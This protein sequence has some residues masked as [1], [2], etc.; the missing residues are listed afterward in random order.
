MLN[1][2][3]GLII[4]LLTVAVSHVWAGT[5]TNFTVGD[6]LIGFREAGQNNLVVDAGQISTFTNAAHNQVIPISQYTPNQLATVG[7]NGL[8][9]SAFSW[10]D[11][12]VT[13]A[14]AQWTLF[15]TTPRSSVNVKS[16]YWIANAQSA[17]SQ[18]L[19][20]G[21]M[22]QIPPGA[23][24][25]LFFN[26]ANTKTAIV[27]PANSIGS[28][29]YPNG[30]SY[31]D[32][33]YTQNQQGNFNGDLNGFPENTTPNN[34][35]TAGT[36]QRSDFYWVPP[37]DSGNAVKYLGYFE[38]NT[39]G[40]LSFVA[41]PTLPAVTSLTASNITAANALLSA[42]INPN[43]STTSLFF[44][45]GLTTSYGSNS[46]VSNIG[47]TSGTY[48]LAVSN[49]VG[50]TTYHF[51][52]V[53]YNIAGTNFGSDLTFTTTGGAV[54]KPVVTAFSRTNNASYIT[55]TTG[56]SGIY[57]LHG[58]NV[59]SGPITNWPVIIAIPGDGLSHTVS[60][61]TTAA[62]MFYSISAQ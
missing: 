54:T 14:S 31:V 17:A 42:S 32:A 61:N 24:A 18:S 48:G 58:T 1:R 23:L 7:T 20:A 25:N 39:N 3:V 8:T 41:S 28:A 57:T 62:S 55:F 11:D 38:L 29:D 6:V 43:S 5:F 27:E 21:D 10:F 50:G 44:Q 49:L 35:T 36:V 40:A 15:V 56:N 4:L 13:P 45:Y 22:A 34:F 52:A 19:P 46:V 53:A 2:K 47:T 30:L 59:L 26:V 33:I 37:S 12:S 51:R 16:T 60:N 9:W